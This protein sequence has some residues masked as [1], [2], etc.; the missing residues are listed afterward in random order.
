MG[1]SKEEFEIFK[2]LEE[3][4]N[5]MIFAEDLFTALKGYNDFYRKFKLKEI[6][7]SCP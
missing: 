2:K 3:F 7:E 6:S 4:S 1:K 5:K